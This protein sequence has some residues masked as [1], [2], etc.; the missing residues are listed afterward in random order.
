MITVKRVY[1]APAA[2]DGQRFLVDRLWP[3]GVKKDELRLDGWLKEVAPSDAL[4]KWFGH[5]PARWEEF[6][7]RYFAE[8]E[9]NPDAWQPLLTAARQGDVTLLYSARDEAHNNAVALKAFLERYLA[10]TET[11]HGE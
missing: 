1:E 3:R 6:Q 4:R 5:D 10:D 11:A 2:D 7:Q 9:A 8:L